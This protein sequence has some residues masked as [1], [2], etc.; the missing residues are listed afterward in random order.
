M[1]ESNPQAPPAGPQFMTVD[2]Q[3]QV[4]RAQPPQTAPT[5]AQQIDAANSAPASGDYALPPIQVN[6]EAWTP[7]A[8]AQA[9][10]EDFKLAAHSINASEYE[11][12]NAI[13]TVMRPGS[14]PQA[15]AVVGAHLTNSW[16]T[17]TAERAELVLQAM[18]SSP[19]L[20]ALLNKY[21]HAD[22][23]QTVYRCISRRVK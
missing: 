5:M 23:V 4:V 3:G 8:Q 6:G 16:G 9:E 1:N 21:P 20:A 22:F 2:D 19:R 15:P 17:K 12:Q 13:E 18:E 11:F 7:D 10:I 14:T